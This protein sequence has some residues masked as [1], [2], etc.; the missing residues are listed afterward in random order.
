MITLFDILTALYLVLLGSLI[1]LL[2]ILTRTSLAA[3]ITWSMLSTSMETTDVSTC[4]GA[5]RLHVAMAETPSD[6]TS[7]LPSWIVTDTPEIHDSLSSH[8]IEHVS[9]PC[10]FLR[11]VVPWNLSLLVL[12]SMSLLRVRVSYI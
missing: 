1:M 4:W 3:S 11:L 6:M 12:L 2:S 10:N 8:I 7:C 9:P 5:A